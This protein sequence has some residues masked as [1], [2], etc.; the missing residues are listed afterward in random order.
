MC[1]STG[2][3][4]PNVDP[5][6]VRFAGDMSYLE[7]L[8]VSVRRHNLSQDPKAFAAN[9]DIRERLTAKGPEGL[10]IILVNDRV[11]WEATYPTRAE[12]A[13]ALGIEES[14]SP[15]IFSESV[16]TLVALGA[17]VAANCEPCFRSHYDAARK[18]GILTEDMLAAVETAK[19]VKAA[20]DRL[21]AR[22]TDRY[23]GTRTDD[24]PTEKR[25]EAPLPMVGS[26]RCC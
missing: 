8:G 15:R 13:G 12:L 3:C 20:P 19:A 22:L 9:A 21:M 2:V 26:S 6:L 25:V 10:P 23:L 1:C 4:G 14:T 17:A 5:T 7:H 24:P 16:K 18:L 11:T